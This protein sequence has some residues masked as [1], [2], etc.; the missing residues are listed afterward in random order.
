[1]KIAIM[2]SGGVGGYFGGRLAASG[3]DV[4]FIARGG[5]LAAIRR[6]GLRIES[7]DMPGATVDPADAT[8]DPASVGE[9]D[10]VIIGVKLWATEEAG[11]AILPMV[12]RNTTV[13]SLQNGVECDDILADIVGRDRLIGGVAFIASSIAR[14]GVIAHIG[15]MQRVVIGELGGGS[16]PRVDR[17]RAAMRDAGIAADISDDIQRTIWEK[18]VFLVGLSAT[19]TLMRT[20]IG[21]IRQDP[22]S[23][24]FLHDVMREAVAVG[25]AR[26]V[27]LPVDY[28]DDRLAFADGLP[29]D[30]TSSMYHDF[31]RGN[32]LEVGWLSGT[33]VRFGR[34]LGVPAPVNQ[35]V[36]AVLKTKAGA[37]ESGT[38]TGPR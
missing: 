11:R 17:L 18:F 13:L 36:Y 23:R 32:R 37:R 6:D 25:R 38:R 3:V 30:M 2:G 10:Y 1:M 24:A 21:P 19:T 15:T 7:R 34:T 20:T 14:P 22:D 12:G 33:V 4:T 9:V 29:Y 5:H 28:A 8:D 35:A 16:S 31:E 26:G 27:A